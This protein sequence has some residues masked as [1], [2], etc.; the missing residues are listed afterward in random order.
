MKFG[1]AIIPPHL[2]IG[3]S[4]AQT[5]ANNAARPVTGYLSIT[6]NLGMPPCTWTASMSGRHR[7]SC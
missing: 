6:T 2:I 1:I 7:C 5:H 3:A 4:D